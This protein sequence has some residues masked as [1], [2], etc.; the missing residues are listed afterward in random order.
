[1]ARQDVNIG[2]E[3][4]DGTGDSIRESFRKVNE[5]FT[6]LYA[7]FGLGGKIS[8]QNLA[9]TPENLQEFSLVFVGET[10]LVN[11]PEGYT[12]IQYVQLA[13]DSAEAGSATDSIEISYDTA[14][15]I[16]LKTT[17]RQVSQDKTPTLGGGLDSDGFGIVG[18]TDITDELAKDI[19]T[20]Y[21]I[22]DLV[23]TKG[24]ADKS[25]IPNNIPFR[26]GDEPD[27][28]EHRIDMVG[29]RNGNVYA[30][31]HG[32]TATIN[33]TPFR[34]VAELTAHTGLTNGNTYYLRYVSSSELQLHIS[35]DFAIN[36]TETEATQRKVTIAN[37]TNF[38][39]VHYLIDAAYDETL[40]GTYLSNQ[41]VPR[42][43]TVRRQG[44]KMTGPLV[45]HDSPGELSG[46]TSN[47]EDLQAATK[48]YVDNTSYSSPENLY[49]SGSGDD[50]MRGVPQGRE[51]TS[52]S[53]AYSS[54]NAACRR[55][56]EIIEAA[57][58]EPGPYFQTL[59]KNA[60]TPAEILE[61]QVGLDTSFVTGGFVYEP[62]EALLSGNREWFIKEIT[63]YLK[64]KYPD[65][66]YNVEL[67]ERDL[68]LI[69]DSIALD[70]LR[71]P[72]GD[73]TANFLT[74]QAAKKYYASA[75]GRIAITRQLTET[76]DAIQ[77]ARE[78]TQDVLFNRM[79][80]QKA[81]SDITQSDSSPTVTT[82]SNHDLVTGNLVTFRNVLGMTEINDEI[83]YVKVVD[84]TNFLIYED[85][86]FL[87]P[88]DTTQFTEYD[89]GGAIGLVYQ[90]DARQFFTSV[91]AQGSQEETDINVARQAI[92]DKFNIVVDVITGGL[93]AAPTVEYGRTWSIRID[94]GVNE[95]L[96]QT[97]PN[98]GDVLPGK[99]VVG[100]TSGAI[101][102]VVEVLTEDPDYDE[103]RMH[104]L[105][106]FKF[107]PGE[108]L[109][110]GNFVKQKQI[111]VFVESGFFEE[112]YPI[113]VPANVSVVGDEFRRV[114]VR[115]KNRLS[116]SKWA[117]TYFYRDTEFDGL[118]LVEQGTPFYNQNNEIQG[119]F[120]RHYL[121]NPTIPVEVGPTVV[122]AGEYEIAYN[123]IQENIEFIGKEVYT[124]LVNEV[125]DLIFDKTEFRSRFSDIL[126]KVALDIALNTNY[127]S[128]TEG[129]K[130]QR[131][132]DDYNDPYLKGLW[133][134]ALTEARDYITT[135]TAFTG[136][137]GPGSA[138]ERSNNLFNE[139]IDIIQNGVTSTDT[140]ADALT[141]D[142]SLSIS[143]ANIAAKDRLQN[144]KAFL[145]AEITAWIAANYP[146][147]QY[148]SEKCARDVGYIV[149]ALSYDILY[150]CN[151]ATRAAAEAY[152]RGT[153]EVSQLGAGQQD[154]TVESYE[155]LRDVVLQVILG[156]S[157]TPTTGNTE[158][159][160]TSGANP[161]GFDTTLITDVSA[162]GG[163]IHLIID[164]IEIGNLTPIA[165][166]VET[167]PSTAI[168]NSAPTIFTDGRNAINGFTAAIV[169]A[170]ETEMDSTVIYAFSY[171]DVQEEIN[172][173][174]QAIAKDLRN[175]GNEFAEQAQNDLAQS[176]GFG[177]QLGVKRGAVTY[178]GEVI[179]ELLTGD[180]NQVTILQNTG[181]VYTEPD[182]QYGQ[183]EAGASTAVTN[184]ANKIAF[185]T[186][187][188]WN[189]P[190]RNDEL[191]VFLMND[192]T[193]LRN[194]TV[195]GHGG[196]LCVLDP[197]GQIL[198]KS[199][200]IQTGSSFSRSINDKIFAGGM[201]VDAFTGNLPVDIVG[202]YPDP[203]DGSDSHK[204]KID[205]K[206]AKGTGITIRPPQLPCP[207]YLEGRRYQINSI[208]YSQDAGTATLFLDRT[209]NDKNGFDLAEFT[210][211]INQSLP[212]PIALQTAGNRSMLGNDFTQ[213]NDLG[214]GLVTNNGAFSEMVSMFTYYCQ[215]AYYAKNGS[216]I[217]SLNGS[218]GYGKFG[219]V[220]EGASPNEIPDQVTL[221]QNMVKPAKIF[222]EAQYDNALGSNTIYVTDLADAPTNDSRV[223]IDHGDLDDVTV[224]TL[225]YI[226]GSVQEIKSV[227]VSGVKSY[228]ATSGGAG[229]PNGSFE[230]V[231][232]TGGSGSGAVFNVLIT[233]SGIVLELTSAGENYS[234]NDVLTIDAE[235]IGGQPG[236]PDVT[237]TVTGVW[238][239][240]YQVDNVN[241]GVGLP[242]G[243]TTGINPTGGNGAGAV[244]TVDIDS[245]GR[246]VVTITDP[247]EGYDDNDVLTIA[248][249]A[250]SGAAGTEPDITFNVN[251]W[252][253][254]IGNPQRDNRVFVLNIKEDTLNATDD[255]GRL[256]KGLGGGS[257]IDYFDNENLQFTGVKNA[258]DLT[259]RP[260]TAINFDESDNVTYRSIDF[261]QVNAIGENLNPNPAAK[262]QIN[263]TVDLGFAD[264]SFGRI[265]TKIKLEGVAAGTG[266]NIGDRA[267]VVGSILDTDKTPNK[268][269]LLR[270]LAGLQPPTKINVDAAS[271]I[272]DNREYVQEETIAWVNAQAPGAYNQDKLYEDIGT[273][274]DA[275]EFDLKFNSNQKTVDAA[276]IHVTTQSVTIGAINKAK[277]IINDYVLTN[278]AWSTV[279][280]NGVTQTIDVARTAETGADTTVGNLM[281]VVT[282]VIANGVGNA[283][284]RSGYSG[285]MIMAYGGKTH[286]AIGL[287]TVGEGNSEVNTIE[288]FD[289]PGTNIDI[290]RIG[291]EG[292]NKVFDVDDRPV[293][294][295]LAKDSTAEIT[296]NISLC[297]ATGHD[298][299]QI[300]TGGYNDSN[301]PNVILGKPIG[302]L[303][304]YY[305]DAPDAEKAQ[306]WERRKGRV[307]WASTD[308]YG[309]F[310]VGKFFSVDQAQGSIE[311]S[312]EIGITDAIRLGFKKGVTISEFSN[313]PAMTDESPEAV[314]TEEAV[315]AYINRRLGWT[316]D[317]GGS[318]LLPLNNERLG[319]G[320][321]T[322]NGLTQME[323]ELKMGGFRISGVLS[324]G[325]SDDDAANKGYVDGI[326]SLYDT[327]DKQRDTELQVVKKNDILVATGLY[328]IY[329]NN[330]VTGF[331]IDQIITTQDGTKRGQI[332]DL[333]TYQDKINGQ[334]SNNYQITLITYE[335]LETVDINGNPQGVFDNFE[336]FEAIE[337]P[338]AGQ[339]QISILAG[340][341]NE[342]ANAAQSDNS[343]ID[344]TVT[345]NSNVTNPAGEATEPTATI[346][347]QIINDT[348]ID[349]DVKT[350][351]TT[352]QGI[353]QDKLRMR[354]AKILDD[355]TGLYGANGANSYDSVGQTDRGLAA[356]DSENLA[357]EI[358]LTL[359]QSI[360]I[361]EGDILI[362]DNGVTRYVGTVA[363]TDNGASLIIIRTTDPWAV[364]GTVLKKQV[365]GTGPTPAG[366]GTEVGKL[367]TEVTLSGVSVA[368]I[369]YSG[370]IT[371]KDRALAYTKLP[372]MSGATNG[373]DGYAIG[374]YHNDTGTPE[375]VS[376]DTI[377]DQGL[378]VQ[379]KDFS[380]S[381]A[382]AR[383]IQQ[384]T[385][386]TNKSVTN[387]VAVSQT[388]GGNTISGTVQG[389]T[390]SEKTFYVIDITDTA[391]SATPT[392]VAGTSLTVGGTNIGA[393]SAVAPLGENVGAALIKLDEG[394]YGTTEISVT[395]DGDTIARRDTNGRLQAEAFVIGTSENNEILSELSGLLTFK[396]PGQ[397][398]I[399]EATGGSGG[400]NPTYPVVQMPGSLNVG[401]E[402][403]F[404]A[405]SN[406][407]N[408]TQ[409][410]AQT[411]QT[412]PDLNGEG[413]ISGPW[414]YTNF[415]EALDTKDGDGDGTRATTG[416]QLGGTVGYNKGGAEKIVL[417]A[418]QN[419][420]LVVDGSGTGAITGY[421]DFNINN[422]SDSANKFSVAGASGNI[423]TAGSYT[424]TGGITINTNK[425][426][427]D[428]SD[429][430]TSIAGTLGVGD[431]TDITGNLTVDGNVTLG[432]GSTDTIA[433]NGRVNTNILPSTDNNRNLGGG[434]N[435][436]NTVYASIFEGTATTAQYADL[437]ENYLGDAD[438]EP[439]TVLVF[440]GDAEVT[441]TNVKG[442]RKVAGIVTTN[443]AHLMNS[444][445]KGDNVVGVAL[446]GRV[447][448]KVI[449]TVFKG[450]ML[451]T[452][453]V[454]GYA[455][456]NNDPKVGTVIGKAVGSKLGDDKGIVE[457]VVGRV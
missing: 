226:I 312:G 227:R 374:R 377:I 175:G 99:V 243:S 240:F 69:I 40:E 255:F 106:P 186:D 253:D 209:S 37:I 146:R 163:L 369:K 385:Y 220:S 388:V 257:I 250:I 152:F 51:G 85:E 178:L 242:Q 183:A 68:G 329:T 335:L 244:A 55:A 304:T 328:K 61:P 176:T 414:M 134:T 79:Y 351:E 197:D 325:S 182:L 167:E 29:I 196:F 149:D 303:A 160:D 42:K 316:N 118:T 341:F 193:I 172:T 215:A 15:K 216:E 297:R 63:A 372:L 389:S 365:I 375:E 67:C 296:I 299:T 364:S 144:N 310:R 133:V 314:P 28:S 265:E 416:I 184:L 47:D 54:I 142:E 279:N 71:G 2:V 436:W 260:S 332:K 418:G 148:N 294:F 456:V 321:L 280:A 406:E 187:F 274:I 390:F 426:T 431:D 287:G 3:G 425:F 6:E 442:D 192:A 23:I 271:L 21:S 49:V 383:N 207:F 88:V 24:Y 453:A 191:D 323:G 138:T 356:F 30:P 136:S 275:V 105:Q 300:G 397:G 22:S 313:D 241:G 124:H 64:F 228:S 350:P 232:P 12:P 448:C 155:H 1:M 422:P 282:D 424:G 308:Q 202:L 212:I 222:A 276:T 89:A 338:L 36:S 277:E 150:S 66:A 362:Q 392:F 384:I 10:D 18:V 19:D 360:T 82:S 298:F 143:A 454:P 404:G 100:K 408:S 53:Y 302:G 4:N 195:Q 421:G 284:A 246:I 441:I 73:P 437:A 132:S 177:D 428:G 378:G 181:G 94:D 116:Q 446:Q 430:N 224:G 180:I 396:T 218:N 14:G 41:A 247:G 267:M 273:V 104:L 131:A 438:Y 432:D 331:S 75:S 48:F 433:V 387:G 258:D 401:K 231:E 77:T 311:F 39:D 230:A 270:D 283:P 27:V 340:P 239:A 363:K 113:K 410:Q 65:F 234:V 455:I 80:L 306:V 151:M 92:R 366:N 109:R 318:Q 420:V 452:S 81:I 393:P 451:V 210:D 62:A 259:E 376:F 7:V 278:T 170:G 435:R 229:I 443:P 147:L 188:R 110:F 43:S 252:W 322:L 238:G 11:P 236:D 288:L 400:Q 174:A 290:T 8:F 411:A 447:P 84:A 380:N 153:F 349:A 17:F 235:D 336:T 317:A 379:D 333:A 166:I 198:T 281:D 445:L 293:R 429:G 126:R 90:K 164:T 122:N 261:E 194:L 204:F 415:V 286:Q 96:D 305:S 254:N 343:V 412:S 141:F 403:T 439:G 111:T 20:D 78:Y 50:T 33:G 237:F 165:G 169:N 219:L 74:I 354:R 158:T 135:L 45:L 179:N 87:T 409:G 402:A 168:I 98:E 59:Y 319:P 137:T 382:T 139:L 450:D 367:S 386:T 301:Y 203:G 46:L 334:E 115:P 391:G 86:N 35:A 128:V 34:Y 342:Y 394:V 407:V 103:I 347:L 264:N 417:V 189:P 211:A 272:A 291:K 217:R 427:V 357:E 161:S 13:S 91:P 292:I 112:D 38:S 315:V 359:S 108:E 373:V 185:S 140:A 93:D 56:E 83:Y 32:Y 371:V 145:K 200:Y 345:R 70:L 121:S 173:L 223:V 262:N 269:R 419:Q 327:V 395:N 285:G 156:N 355:A 346:D 307:F 361:D 214:Y 440:G 251:G 201:F 320:F 295:M 213:I 381:E 266:A 249:S 154:I 208:D 9:D 434:S 206:S 398:V 221:L 337:G 190:R 413:F 162:D 159:Q 248:S 225:N 119:L 127:H 444:E 368:G 123:T 72:D 114:I 125:K 449:G 399:L 117:N 129:L 107:I 205:V 31:N 268:T 58:A 263:S 289:V 60:G 120:G 97:K 245:E 233:N 26:I 95:Y 76:V 102:R 405:G 130:F 309:F 256:Q 353:Q 352:S 199:P 171:T 57:P 16:V 324:P 344:I 457:V 52:W 157:V 5:N 348:I 370:F 358:E 330:P 101:G 44:D 339:A 326:V 423:V 25:Y